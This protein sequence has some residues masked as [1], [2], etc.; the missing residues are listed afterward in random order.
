MHCLRL[1][2][3]PA[4]HRQAIKSNYQI[5]E[6]Y[7]LV[8]SYFNDRNFDAVSEA[9]RS[10]IFMYLDKDKLAGFVSIDLKSA[11][12]QNKK[13]TI[14][15]INIYMVTI[16]E[17]Y[18][19]QGL[20][21]KI[22]VEAVEHLKKMHSLPKETIIALHLSPKDPCMPIAGLAYYK[23]GFRK[24]VF[25]DVGPVEYQHKINQLLENSQDLCLVAD[26]PSIA[27]GKGFYFL[28]FCKLG[29][30]NVDLKIESES[31]YE[32]SEKLF[33]ILKT[34]LEASPGET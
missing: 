27:S 16:I 28:V 8:K 26:D 20:A 9:T 1:C 11:Y 12:D 25:S 31:V 18:R 14:P 33:G 2:A 19:G 13:E 22:I 32:K 17:E 7:S 30:L 3:L 10:S 21:K 6:H 29:D 5:L 34:R 24:G 23:L 15:Y 4:N